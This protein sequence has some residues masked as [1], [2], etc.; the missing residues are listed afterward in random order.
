MNICGHK[1]QSKKSRLRKNNEL[2]KFLEIAIFSVT[3]IN[4]RVSLILT[5]PWAQ[6][7]SA[8]DYNKHPHICNNQP[9]LR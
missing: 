6:V 4:V 2:N 5:P 3:S 8:L 7:Q 9:K 1:V